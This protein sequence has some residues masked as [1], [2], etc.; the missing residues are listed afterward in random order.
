MISF[1]SIN[2]GDHSC[3]GITAYLSRYDS[4]QWSKAQTSCFRESQLRRGSFNMAQSAPGPPQNVVS[5]TWTLQYLVSM[6]SRL[7]LSMSLCALIGWTHSSSC[8]F[9]LSNASLTNWYLRG[10]GAE[11]RPEELLRVEQLVS[12]WSLCTCGSCEPWADSLDRWAGYRWNRRAWAAQ[13]GGV[14][15]T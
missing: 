13:M 11:V 9:R 7:W 2:T 12:G 8:F 15:R 10:G 4:L 6:S 1:Y 14:C 5:L 3:F